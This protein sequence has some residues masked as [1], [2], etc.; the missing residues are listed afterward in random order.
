MCCILHLRLRLHFLSLFNRLPFP[1]SPLR[2]MWFPGFFPGSLL[3]WHLWI[4][5]PRFPGWRGPTRQLHPPSHCMPFKGAAWGWEQIQV[6]LRA[7]Q[8]NLSVEIDW[9]LWYVLPWLLVTSFTLRLM[10]HQSQQDISFNYSSSS[11]YTKSHSDMRH[12]ARSLD[13]QIPRSLS[14]QTDS[15]QNRDTIWFED[16]LRGDGRPFK[17]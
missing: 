3:R 2:C 11:P 5:T 9:E 1:L 16:F 12:W 17:E 8:Q 4:F 14:Q 6:S 7:Q 15:P 13:A 10:I